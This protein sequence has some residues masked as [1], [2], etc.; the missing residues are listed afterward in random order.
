M[1]LLKIRMGMG[2]GGG[3]W[4][5]D[6]EEGDMVGGTEAEEMLSVDD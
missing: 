3:G 2:V 1:V 6:E 5:E 4:G